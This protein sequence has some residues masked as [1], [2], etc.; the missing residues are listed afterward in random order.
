MQ[1]LYAEAPTRSYFMDH[2]TYDQVQMPEGTIGDSAGFMPG[3]NQQSQV[4][5]FNGRAVGV[6]LPNFIEQAVVEADPG[7]RGDTATGA[8]KPAENLHRRQRQRAALHQRRRRHQRSTRARGSTSSASA[9]PSGLAM[10]ATRAALEARGRIVGA[11]RA[12]FEKE[13]FL[14]VSTPARVRSPGQEVHLEA[15]PRPASG[16]AL[17]D[18]L[19]RVPPQA[20]GRRTGCRPSSRSAVL[21]RRR[22]ARTTGPSSPCSSGTGRTH[23]SRCW[24]PTAR[25]WSRLPSGPRVAIHCARPRRALRA[26]QHAGAVRAPCRLL[27]DRRRDPRRAARG[28]REGR[29]PRRR[30][31]RLGR[32]LLSGVPRSHRTGAGAGRAR[33]SSSTGRRRSARW[34][35]PSVRSA[36]G[37]AVRALRGGLELANAFGELTDP[38]SSA[39]ASRRRPRI[40]AAR[41]K[42]VYPIDEAL[43]A[44]LPQMPPTAGIALGST[45]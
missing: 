26:D 36:P 15:I 18:H 16:D 4:L 9:A 13:G 7:F 34:R 11:V 30:G 32:H 5:F 19:A 22:V 10:P 33:R 35:G 23:R 37:G 3:N 25:R 14:E 38:S 24:P 41:G 31:D 20:S 21:A 39:G 44:A 6:T 45:D 8:T 17:A 1:Y 40:R 29:G 28:G 27:S 12:W 42:A 43:L 2:A